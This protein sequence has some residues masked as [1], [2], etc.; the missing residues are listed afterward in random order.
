MS[1]KRCARS[2]GPAGE[3]NRDAESF[4]HRYA[5]GN[6]PGNSRGDGG[7]PALRERVIAFENVEQ[8]LARGRARR[9]VVPRRALAQLV[10]TT[11]DPVEILIEQNR[12]RLKELVPLRFARMLTDPFSFYRGPPR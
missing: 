8:D 5:F 7:E 3:L 12:S 9:K 1:S 6:D 2:C 4:V 10:P 11:R